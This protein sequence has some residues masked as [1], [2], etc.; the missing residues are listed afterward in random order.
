[1]ASVTPLSTMEQAM[2]YLNLRSPATRFLGVFV[3]TNVIVWWVKP[4]YFFEQVTMKP[5]PNAIVPWWSLGLATGAIA[6]FFL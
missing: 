2:W 6:A 4:Q 3:A 1:M 5:S